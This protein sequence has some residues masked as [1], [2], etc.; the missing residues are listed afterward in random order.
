MNNYE[1]YYEVI[2]AVIGSFGTTARYFNDIVSGGK[3]FIFMEFLMNLFSG[4]FIAWLCAK[5]SV[6]VAGLSV[7]IA[8]IVAGVSGVIGFGASVS[9]LNKVF[10]NVFKKE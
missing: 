6:A 3:K 2:W 7:D 9:V 1:K 10:N 8:F 5:T 4:G